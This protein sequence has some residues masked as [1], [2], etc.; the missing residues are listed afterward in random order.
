MSEPRPSHRPSAHR[1][2]PPANEFGRSTHGTSK[3]IA[4]Q[5][6]ESARRHS[7]SIPF[8]QSTGQDLG[9]G[10]TGGSF[11]PI[12]NQSGE[13]ETYYPSS[14]MLSPQG[15][16]AGDLNKGTS[17]MFPANPTFPNYPNP[18]PGRTVFLPCRCAELRSAQNKNVSA[19]NE[20]ASFPLK[21][22]DQDD[23]AQFSFPLYNFPRVVDSGPPESTDT[24]DQIQNV[25]LSNY[26]EVKPEE[27]SSDHSQAA[28]NSRI[29]APKPS[30]DLGTSAAVNSQLAG[31]QPKV[32]R[33]TSV[34]GS[35]KDVVA[36][37]KAPFV[38]HQYPKKMCPHCNEHP[39]GFRGEHELR[40][41]MDRAHASTKHMFVCV[42][43]TPE[44]NF[45]ANC[46]QCRNGKKYNAYYNAA[47]HLRRAHFNP[48][49]QR[50]RGR[51]RVDEKRGGKGGGDWPPMEDLRKNYMKQ[52]EVQVNDQDFSEEGES[53]ES[54]D[55]ANVEGQSE[56][57]DF[58]SIV[59]TNIAPSRGDGD[60][61]ACY[62]DPSSASQADVSRTSSAQNTS[63]NDRSNTETF[64][65]ASQPTQNF[66]VFNTGEIDETS[67]FMSSHDLGFFTENLGSVEPSVIQ[68]MMQQKS[69]VQ[70]SP[71]GVGYDDMD[72]AYSAQQ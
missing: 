33:I 61:T 67:Y 17:G 24:Q 32:N 72:W 43:P 44:R 30:Y 16:V 47:A 14:G 54:S 70:Q 12:A 26:A 37:S 25:S 48:R 68:G 46:K 27:R 41:H 65:W 20:K 8:G 7:A 18:T 21:G 39:E 23:Q 2:F 36:I 4:P 6:V 51:G 29:I 11:T 64:D 38:R 55:G 53:P 9:F 22:S 71:L 52:V 62:P 60:P 34:D 40:R 13:L 35:L 59:D 28:K 31:A 10:A 63:A 15:N 57:F 1:T 42:D 69:M 3:P 49:K 45:L 5:T 66:E 58:G 50:G 19:R 56:V